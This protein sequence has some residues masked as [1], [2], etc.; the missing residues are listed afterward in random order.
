MT[1]PPQSDRRK[2]NCPQWFLPT[3]SLLSINVIV[4]AA[5]YRI[6]MEYSG[7]GSLGQPYRGFLF[8]YC[9]FVNGCWVLGIS[10]LIYLFNWLRD[11]GGLLRGIELNTRWPRLATVE[12]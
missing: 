11:V 5:S 10:L 12:P 9:F 8:A 4:T 6:P 2:I 3:F 1:T 7:F